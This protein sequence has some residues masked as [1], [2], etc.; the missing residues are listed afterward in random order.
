MAV[1]YCGTVVTDLV[2]DTRVTK[3]FP[4]HISL[5]ACCGAVCEWFCGLDCGADW[6]NFGIP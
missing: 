5:P 3:A 2:F 6:L 4:C 1:S